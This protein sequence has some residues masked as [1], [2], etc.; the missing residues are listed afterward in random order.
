[1]GDRKTKTNTFTFE[2]TLQKSLMTSL[3][4]LLVSFILLKVRQKLKYHIMIFF[5]Y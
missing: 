3:E 1:M 4:M 2:L 5:T